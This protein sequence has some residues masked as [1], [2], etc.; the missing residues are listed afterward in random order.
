M[1][2]ERFSN[3][4]ILEPTV[5]EK[6][7]GKYFLC[8]CDCGTIKKVSWVT[9]KNGESKS[10]GCMKGKRHSKRMT[11]HGMFGTRIYRI[12]SQ[13]KSRCYN[14]MATGY[15]YWGG[16]GV[17]VCDGWKNS[18]EK[19]Y[20]WALNNGYE[21]NLSIDRIDFNGNY[22]PSNCRWATAKEQAENRSTTKRRG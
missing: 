15:K 17:I 18:F 10:C 1:I 4:V 2:G 20:E 8:K 9:L 7:G 13:M 16:K 19:F 11:T 12:W 5:N 3:W 14:E 22:E 6:R 21:D